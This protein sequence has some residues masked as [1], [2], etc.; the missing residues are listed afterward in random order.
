MNVNDYY[1]TESTRNRSDIL[2]VLYNKNEPSTLTIALNL[3][4]TIKVRQNKMHK[5]FKSKFGITSGAARDV[6]NGGRGG[7]HNPQYCQIR[8]KVRQISARL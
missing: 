8:K 3:V 5:N 4:L 2:H 6:P 1:K 7:H